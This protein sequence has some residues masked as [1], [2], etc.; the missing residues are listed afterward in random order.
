MKP[1][2]R[3]LEKIIEQVKKNLEIRHSGWYVEAWDNAAHRLTNAEVVKAQPDL[4]VNFDLAGFEQSTLTDGIAYNLLNCKQIHILLNQRLPNEKCLH[5]PL[6]IAMFFYCAGRE[7]YKYLLKQYPELPFLQEISGW[8]EED[9]EA[10]VME[11]AEVLCTMILETT[12][13]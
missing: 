1:K 6:S 4:F 10:A 13:L 7:Y 3:K 9:T 8:K 2:G 11:N 12:K 5:K